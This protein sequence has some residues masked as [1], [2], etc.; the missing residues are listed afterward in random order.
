MAVTHRRLTHLIL[1]CGTEMITARNAGD[2]WSPDPDKVTCPDCRL[3]DSLDVM[4]IQG[5]EITVKHHAGRIVFVSTA[6]ARIRE[7]AIDEIT[8][9]PRAVGLELAPGIILGPGTMT[10]IRGWITYVSWEAAK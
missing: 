3:Q 2:G 6:G 5:A 9:A 1:D 10:V 8:D 4:S 7:I